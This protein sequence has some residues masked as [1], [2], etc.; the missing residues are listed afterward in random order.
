MRNFTGDWV[1]F[2]NGLR[3]QKC[4]IVGYGKDGNE[5]YSRVFTIG[6]TFAMSETAEELDILLGK[7]YEVKSGLE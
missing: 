4:H 5:V 7:E 6:Q 2:G 3:L 1:T